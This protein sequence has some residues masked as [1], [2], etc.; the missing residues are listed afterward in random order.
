MSR[1]LKALATIESK[2]ATL[3]L[4]LPAES[5]P[6]KPRRRKGDSAQMSLAALEA[7]LQ[8]ALDAERKAI[9]EAEADESVELFCAPGAAGPALG[10]ADWAMLERDDS[11]ANSEWVLRDS[12]PAAQATIVD[13]EFTAAELEA[14]DDPAPTADELLA[15]LGLTLS[16]AEEVLERADLAP[17]D[18]CEADW[19]RPELE[20]AEPIAIAQE[21]QEE[22]DETIWVD[23]AIEIDFDARC[24]EVCED[25]SAWTEALETTSAE[26]DSLEIATPSAL[27]GWPDALPIVDAPFR[28]DECVEVDFNAFLSH[29]A[30]DPEDWTE[31]YE[32]SPAEAC[33][34]FA[35]DAPD[36]MEVDA[37][38]E[39]LPLTF[40]ESPPPQ[41]AVPPAIVPAQTIAPPT[42][43]PRR[44]LTSRDLLS[45]EAAWEACREI[46]N[47]LL[48]MRSAGKPTVMLFVELG[49]AAATPTI[50]PISAMLAESIQERVLLVDTD[51][52]R[53]DAVDELQGVKTPGF[54]DLLAKPDAWPSL[55]LPSA[56]ARLDLMPAGA[57]SP[58][59][60]R[61]S[62]NFS[63]AAWLESVARSY[64]LVLLHAGTLGGATL[65]ELA[66]AADATLIVAPLGGIDRELA[67]ETVDRLRCWGANV[68]G[69]IVLEESAATAGM[70]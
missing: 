39:A 41:V 51:Y 30:A 6:Q 24:V 23:D 12:G 31:G 22:V 40:I 36:W 16:P 52:W 17:L 15:S 69:C 44:R 25:H 53:A 42:I 45:D 48:T 65:A 35:L 62:G 67:E 34:Q 68:A 55:V 38:I 10:V 61:S 3:T 20:V 70:A 8:A 66:A 11:D 2:G 46:V 60:R 13:R 9:I 50:A 58:E 4:S 47:G 29:A 27:P 19:L 37:A 64:D 18:W 5:S 1:I 56:V 59:N 43:A 26:L 7:Y 14:F 63:A 57:P 33:E 49:A 54:A 32:L 21:E 28:D